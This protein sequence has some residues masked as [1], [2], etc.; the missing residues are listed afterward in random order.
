MALMREIEKRTCKAADCK[1]TAAVEVLD[2]NFHPIG[3]FCR[4]D[5]MKAMRDQADKEHGTPKQSAIREA[6]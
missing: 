1:A 3:D 6:V 5:G 2:D 4:R